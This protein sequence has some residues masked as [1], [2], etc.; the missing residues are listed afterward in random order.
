MTSHTDNN[1]NSNDNTGDL[2]ALFTGLNAPSVTS[3]IEQVRYG[4]RIGDI[5]LLVPEGAFSEVV[6]NKGVYPLPNT[7]PW[8]LGILNDHGDM[9][10]VYD[11]ARLLGIDVPSGKKDALLIVDQ[12]GYA[13]A[14]RVREY[15]RAVRGFEAEAQLPE[16]PAAL[17]GYVDRAYRAGD[18]VWL[19]FRHRDFFT[20][21][22][23]IVAL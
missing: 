16:I 19:D 20:S 18:E 1:G 4:V 11:I 13:A 8:L 22:K 15:P 14:I 23:A 9:V 6:V 10:P 17:D 3:E 12:R 5:G 7:Q 2:N 21:L